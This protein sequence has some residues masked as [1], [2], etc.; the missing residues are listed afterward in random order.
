MKKLILGA[1]L[2]A[3]VAFAASNVFHVTFQTSAWL[4]ATEIKPGDYKITVEDGKA[5]LK[6]GKTLFTAPAS[7]ETGEKVF[8]VTAVI[9]RIVGDKPQ[10]EAIEIGGG[11]TRIVF[12]GPVSIPTG[13]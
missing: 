11:K 9:T 6:A 13:E 2:L 8:R 7:L 5:T 4:G 12:T 3:L 1:M 10:L